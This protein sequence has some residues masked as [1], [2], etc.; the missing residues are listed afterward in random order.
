M[1]KDIFVTITGTNFCYGMKP[2]EISRVVKLIKEPQNAFDSDAIRVEMPFIGKVGY[3]ANSPNTVAKG[4]KSAGRIYDLFHV[5]VFA[6]VL[7]IT[8]SKVICQLIDEC[9][10][11]MAKEFVKKATV[12]K[13][14]KYN[15]HF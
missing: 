14:Y 8:S 3:V 10:A 7:F 1:N 4:T 11:K 12:R 13:R 15:N 6:K 9:E 5:E 2:F